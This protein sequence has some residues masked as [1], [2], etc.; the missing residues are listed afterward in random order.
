MASVFLSSAVNVWTADLFDL[1]AEGNAF[2]FDSEMIV[3]GTVSKRKCQ[4]PDI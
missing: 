2:G 4:Q 1:S 3:F